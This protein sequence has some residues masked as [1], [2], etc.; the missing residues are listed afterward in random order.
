MDGVGKEVNTRVWERGEEIT[1]MMM[2]GK[3]ISYCMWMSQY[4]LE[5]QKRSCCDYFFNLMKCVRGECWD[6]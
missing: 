1:G 5:N 3:M 4:Q 6:K 2:Y